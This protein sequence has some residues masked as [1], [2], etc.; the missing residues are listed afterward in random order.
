MSQWHFEPDTPAPA[1]RDPESDAMATVLTFGKHKGST[2]S[3]LMASQA[4]RSYL[5]WLSL[6]PAEGEWAEAREKRN[7]KIATC[8]SIYERWQHQQQ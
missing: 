7:A 2:F 1:A 5:R 4:G 6:Q 3:A 8:F